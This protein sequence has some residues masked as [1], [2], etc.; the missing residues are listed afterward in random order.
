MPNFAQV[1]TLSNVFHHIKAAPSF[2]LINKKGGAIGKVKIG[3]GQVDDGKNQQASQGY[4]TSHSLFFHF[5]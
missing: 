3:I 4:D 1:N 5:K 2:G